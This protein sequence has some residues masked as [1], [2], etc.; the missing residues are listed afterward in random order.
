MKKNA[1]IILILGI[2]LNACTQAA[3]NFGVHKENPSTKKIESADILNAPLGEHE[4]INGQPNKTASVQSSDILQKTLNKQTEKQQSLGIYDPYRLAQFPMGCQ[5]KGYELCNPIFDPVE[6]GDE[7]ID[8]GGSY[9]YAPMTRL[10][11][12]EDYLSLSRDS[13]IHTLET[14]EIS[15]YLGEWWPTIRHSTDGEIKRLDGNSLEVRIG[16]DIFTCTEQI[17]KG[18]NYMIYFCKMDKMTS[19]WDSDI[20][21]A[22]EPYDVYLN[23]IIHLKKTDKRLKKD[24]LT[25]YFAK[26][27]PCLQTTPSLDHYWSDNAYEHISYS[28]L[29][30]SQEYPYTNE[31][32]WERYEAGK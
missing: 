32:F 29:C 20:H 19:V 9:I 1:L 31:E 17:V 13:A 15:D 2:G 24:K 27:L 14:A 26:Y 11:F 10:Y 28:P 6:L 25:V 7:N 18:K 22:K 12:P 8:L 16:S 5:Y 4:T 30:K 21:P 23:L 3:V